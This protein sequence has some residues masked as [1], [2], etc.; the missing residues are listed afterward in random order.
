MITV[1]YLFVIEQILQ[2]LY[3]LWQGV[4]W[5]G[6]ARQRVAQPS[7]FYT[8]RVALFCPV[9]GIEPGLEQN[10]Q[11]LTE[12][13][14]LQYEIFFSVANS[15][16]PA[17]PILERI[18]AASHRPVHIVRAGPAKDCA[19]K[20]NNLRAA[21]EQVGG[22]FDIL[23]F[24]DS[25]GRPPRRWL[26]HMVAPLSDVHL[27]AATTFRWLIPN[28]PAKQGAFW[29]ALA[30]AWNAPIATYLGEHQNN[31]CWGGG[32]AIR[33]DR[34]EE[35]HVLEAWHGSVSDDFSLTRAINDAGFGIAFLPE[36]LVPSLVNINARGFFE[37][38]AR[39]FII[40]RIYAPKLWL[41]ALTG[42][43]LYCAAVLIGVGLWS[44]NLATGSP[45]LQIL[46]LAS[47]PPILSAI[48]GVQRLVAVMDIL[49]EYREK[50]LAYG[51]A[52]TVLAPV[53]P[54]LSLYDSFAAIFRRQIKWRG[55][56]Y[57]LISPRE[58]RVLPH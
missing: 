43:F 36:C 6:T 32:M 31:F 29:S 57:R 56:R 24:T 49:P 42:H 52:W 38:T 53:V 35:T 14:Y 9:K 13:D 58:T 19:E 27:G 17:C 28:P 50:L 48:R 4:K 25:D 8:P 30:S 1:F 21:V 51:W 33:R 18:A 5:L 46:I 45:S 10:L 23:V 54:F 11:A 47:I 39:Q 7:G 22:E 2:G 41:T 55:H 12:F 40:T 37:F 20:V 34:F 15:Q 26:A 16:D 3:S 44:G